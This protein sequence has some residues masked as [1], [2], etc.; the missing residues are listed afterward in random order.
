VGKRVVAG[1]RAGATIPPVLLLFEL[2]GALLAALALARPQARSVAAGMLFALAGAAVGYALF[3][4]GTERTLTVVH[5]FVA[6]VG[7]RLETKDF[8]IE[9]TRAPEYAWSLLAALFAAGWGAV[10]LLSATRPSRPAP[11]LHPFFWPLALAWTGCAL[12]LAWEKAAAPAELLRPAG[13]DRILLPAGIAAAVLLAERCR[14]L[15]LTLA[16]LTLF[17]T[18]CRLP[19]ACFG[20]LATHG[21]LGTS[22]DVHSVV[23][24][25]NPLAQQPVEVEPGSTEQLAWLV[26]A[27]HLLVYP[28][29]YLL[30]LGGLAFARLMMLR[31]RER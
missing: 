7:N 23:H 28:S 11:A 13:L 3:Q 16:W 4:G 19:I 31:E 26:W 8:E 17:I 24:F 21:E 9:V 29:F 22:L 25:A 6:Y 30:S 5:S 2:G 15:P 12:L 10:A 20:T 14:S 27:P 1:V 18:A